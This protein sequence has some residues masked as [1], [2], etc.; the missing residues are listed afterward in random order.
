MSSTVISVAIAILIIAAAIVWL[1]KSGREQ[2]HHLDRL[3]IN[4]EETEKKD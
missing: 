4:P 2:A 1:I 3:H